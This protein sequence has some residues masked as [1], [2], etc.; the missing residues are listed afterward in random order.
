MNP[1]IA[2]GII[3]GAMLNGTYGSNA[4]TTL[5]L[6]PVLPFAG[7]VLAI[8]FYEFAYKKTTE[9]LEHDIV[10]EEEDGLLDS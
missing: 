1:A 4:L 8:L 7:S 6:Y 10:A 9:A 3:V 2:I 5:W